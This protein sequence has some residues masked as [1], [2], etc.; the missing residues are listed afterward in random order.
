ATNLIPRYI[1]GSRIKIGNS[2]LYRQWLTCC[3]SLLLLIGGSAEVRGSYPAA[4]GCYA[5]D[6]NPLKDNFAS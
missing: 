3:P 1:G 5:G 2:P 4:Y 6:A